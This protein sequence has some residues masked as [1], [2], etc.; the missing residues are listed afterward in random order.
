[1]AG[2]HKRNLDRHTSAEQA[3]NNILT[4]LSKWGATSGEHC[5]SLSAI[6]YVAFP[7]YDFRM[8]QGAAFA[9]ARIVRSMEKRGLVRYHCDDWRRGYFLCA[10]PPNRK[11]S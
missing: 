5:R 6:G 3:E 7:G 2:K 4:A 9:V 8:P 10:L 1:M 11:Q